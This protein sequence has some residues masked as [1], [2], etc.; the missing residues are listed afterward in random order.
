MYPARAE[1]GSWH[2]AN[3]APE[4]RKYERDTNTINYSFNPSDLLKLEVSAYYTKH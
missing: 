4:N 3:N 1:F 2:I